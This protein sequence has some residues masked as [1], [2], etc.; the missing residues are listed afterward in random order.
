MGISFHPHGMHSIDLIPLDLH[1][2]GI[3]AVLV[4]APCNVRERFNDG[5]NG[6]SSRYLVISFRKY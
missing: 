1:E 3:V 6:P 4:A 2:N 5:Y